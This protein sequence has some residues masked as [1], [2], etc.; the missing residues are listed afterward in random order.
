MLT[1]KHI[2]QYA[3]ALIDETTLTTE[4]IR[5]IPDQIILVM[6]EMYKKGYADCKEN[7]HD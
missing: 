1:D 6:V 2:E 4:Y 7:N 3:Q 5:A